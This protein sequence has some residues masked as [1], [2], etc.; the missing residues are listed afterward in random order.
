MVMYA[1][2]VN[3]DATGDECGEV[4]LVWQYSVAIITLICAGV[5]SLCIVLIILESAVFFVATG[6]DIIHLQSFLLL[7]MFSCAF[8]ACL[9]YR[10]G[11][12]VAK[13]KWAEEVLRHSA[14]IKNND[15]TGAG[16]KG[17]NHNATFDVF[18]TPPWR[19]RL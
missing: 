12:A 6:A 17:L 1:L 9:E 15:T 3:G 5:H 2:E 4:E 7:A 18:G 11:Q 8:A 14:S 16:G 10:G 19:G 13:I